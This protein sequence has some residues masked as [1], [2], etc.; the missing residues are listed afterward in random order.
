MSQDVTVAL[1]LFDRST[2]AE[3]HEASSWVKNKM[4]EDFTYQDFL[5][6]P[7]ERK[8]LEILWYYFEFL[9]V[10]VNRKYIN[11]DIVFDQQGSFIVGMW[12]KTREVIKARREDKNAPMYMENFEIL[13]DRYS[14]WAVV[15]RPKLS[16]DRIR[17]AKD[18]YKA[19]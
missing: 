2:S 18:Y 8:K 9:G 7:E 12:E 5:N 13:A 10:L 11:E 16:P 14:E 6:K 3:M 1:T 19:K 17:Q 4:P 15:N